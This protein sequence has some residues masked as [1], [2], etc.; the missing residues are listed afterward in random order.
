L[1]RKEKLKENLRVKVKGMLNNVERK[2]KE[3]PK[4]EKEEVKEERKMNSK[5]INNFLERNALK[6]KVYSNITDF[7][8]W[9]KKH[10]V[11]KKTKVFIITGGYK[12]IREG[13]IKRGWVENKDPKSPC[14]DLKWTLRAR[15]LDHPNLQSHQI[16]N[17]FCKSAA[18]TTKVGL[19]H[20]LK[21]L[22]WFNNVDVDSFYPQ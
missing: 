16:V 7:D 20:S 1:R 6:K 4:E 15:D 17:H 13:L 3:E 8:I 14:F 22:I 11:S 2:I 10:Q 21:N 9:K 12:T 5:D 19:C 18:I